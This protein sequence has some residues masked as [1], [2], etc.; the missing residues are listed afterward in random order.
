[1]S[2]WCSWEDIG[3]DDEGESGWQNT[4][5]GE[6]R[7]YATGWSNHYPTTDGQVERPASVGVAHAPQW[8]VPGHYD[9]TADGDYGDGAPV[10]GWLRLD[11]VTWTHNW[12]T[13]EQVTGPPEC[14]SVVLDEQ[15]ARSLA[16]D[17]LAWADHEKVH[18]T[19]EGDE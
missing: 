1:V 14:H 17:L 18:P 12:K 9:A 19:K 2:I 10:G 13:P 5:R 16:A 11:M 7:S 4:G 15:A 3:Y 8:C 6:V